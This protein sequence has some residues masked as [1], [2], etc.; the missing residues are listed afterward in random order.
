[1]RAGECLAKIG[2]RSAERYLR[3]ALSI[4]PTLKPALYRL[5][6]IYYQSGNYLSA[7]AYI[8]RYF[9]AATPTA[10]ALLLAYNIE[11]RNGANEVAQSYRSQLL[12]N[13]PASREAASVRRR[14][15]GR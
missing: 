11:L 8:E 10:A 2:D 9:A 3:Q 13:F 15:S 6:E 12:S 7:R 4:D 5:A 14:G 1:M